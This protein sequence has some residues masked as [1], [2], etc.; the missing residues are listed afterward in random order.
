MRLLRFSLLINFFSNK[1]NFNK[2]LKLI[3]LGIFLS[4]FAASTAIISF[5]IE[6]EIN[7]LE[8]ELVEYR[9]SRLDASDTI[10]TFDGELR[11]IV[12]RSNQIATRLNS[13]WLLSSTKFGQK[14]FNIIDFYAPEIFT[15]R[16]EWEISNYETVKS[17]GMSLLTIFETFKDETILDFYSVED[18]EKNK[19]KE[20]INIAIET[21][22]EFEKIN[23]KDYE[24]IIFYTNEDDLINQIQQSKDYSLLEEGKIKEDFFKTY[25]VY[26]DLIDVLNQ[27]MELMR[28]LEWSD[29]EFIKEKE[30]KIIDLSNKEKNIILLTFIFQFVIF[31]II[32]LFEVSSVNQGQIKLLKKNRKKIL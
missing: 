11:T 22:K 31:V 20:K 14:S 6:R 10:M 12:R 32:Q 18:I 2:A 15:S 9:Q 1:K 8:Y 17:D 24:E 27:I 5:Y 4:I 23:I 3:N 16:F 19:I 25:S 30:Q 21:I 7:E 28:N 26:Y 13:L 29:G